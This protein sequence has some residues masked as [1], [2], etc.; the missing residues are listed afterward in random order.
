MEAG[1]VLLV[2]SV[3][4]AWMD[5]SSTSNSGRTVTRAAIQRQQK[6]RTY[7]MRRNAEA[8]V[9]APARSYG[10][11]RD[12]QRSR[13]VNQ[14]CGVTLTTLHV[15]LEH[16]A[17]VQDAPG[18][19]VLFLGS[20]RLDSTTQLRVTSATGMNKTASARHVRAQPLGGLPE[21]PRQISPSRPTRQQGNKA[22]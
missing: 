20:R 11:S 6:S 1:C 4:S 12:S 3:P 18:S 10:P 2:L 13:S 22:C 15:F 14:R 16:A 7:E 17:S 9:E 21:G 19:V 8:F 5:E